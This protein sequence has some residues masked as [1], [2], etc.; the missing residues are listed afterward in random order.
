MV[1]CR[2]KVV[3]GTVGFDKEGRSDAGGKAKKSA[4]LHVVSAVFK[5]Y[6]N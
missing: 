3:E 6:E 1:R 5:V 4:L 2:N